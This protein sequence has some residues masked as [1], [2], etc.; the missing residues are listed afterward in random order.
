MGL[1]AIVTVAVVAVIVAAVAAYL[2][3]IIGILF[4][5][6]RNL[7]QILNR[8]IL[9][10]AQKT[11][12]LGSTVGSIAN[13]VSGIERTLANVVPL[14]EDRVEEEDDEDVYTEEAPARRR[15]RQAARARG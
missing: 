14:D 7:D 10:V 4:K 13:D 8:V 1:E 12:N 11:G 2:I 9:D 5:V 6:I 15:G 3:I